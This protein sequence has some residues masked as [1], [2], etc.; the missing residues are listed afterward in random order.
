MVYNSEV[1]VNEG[2][3]KLK[4]MLVHKALETC[5]QRESWRENNLNFTK[6]ISDVQY[7]KSCDDKCKKSGPRKNN[8]MIRWQHIM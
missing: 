2:M 7:L 6:P 4:F 8:F 1:Q 5:R 3:Q